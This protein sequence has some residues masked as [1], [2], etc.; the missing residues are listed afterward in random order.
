VN[1][2]VEVRREPVRQRFHVARYASVQIAGVAERL[3][4][5]ALPAVS[6]PVNDL[7]P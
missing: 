4:P 7:L 1:R 2:T 3:S 6:I 5:L